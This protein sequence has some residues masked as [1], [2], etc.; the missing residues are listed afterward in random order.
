PTNPKQ[1]NIHLPLEDGKVWYFTG[2]PNAGWV[3][4]SPWA[5]VDLAPADQAGSCWA[6]QYWNVAAAPGV[7]TASENGRV[8]EDLDGDGFQGTGWALL[9]MHNG[10]DER[11]EVGQQIQT[12]DHIG[13]P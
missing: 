13:H 7:I 11:A 3:D 8:V 4:G 2:G 12:Y 5:A 9:Y 6:S 1:P 10:T